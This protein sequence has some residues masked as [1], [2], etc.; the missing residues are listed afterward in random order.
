MC[1]F[2]RLLISICI[3]WCLVYTQKK[4]NSKEKTSRM[5]YNKINNS[6]KVKT[7]YGRDITTRELVKELFGKPAS[8]I[9]IRAVILNKDNYLFNFGRK[10]R[11]QKN[12]A[13]TYLVV[14]AVYYCWLRCHYLTVHKYYCNA[15][16]T[17]AE[18][19]ENSK[20]QRQNLELAVR[21]R[22]CVVACRRDDDDGSMWSRWWAVVR[23]RATDAYAPWA[24]RRRVGRVRD[25]GRK[26]EGGSVMRAA[27]WFPSHVKIP[28][29]SVVR[30][31]GV[32]Q[33][34]C[35]YEEMKKKIERN[36]NK[37]HP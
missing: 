14:G 21:R 11:W 7:L 5:K 24:T 35:T 4:H 34:V 2:Y 3:L 30:L 27:H 13:M 9:N 26:S 17:V 25:E 37:N 12:S 19:R 8:D 32:V 36:H 16:K 20:P 18:T 6:N 10:V 1:I 33:S 29:N 15:Q 22:R 23:C 28:W 31:R